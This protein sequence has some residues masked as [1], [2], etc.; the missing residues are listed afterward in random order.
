MTVKSLD[1]LEAGLSSSS[2]E[3]S[4]SKGI[5]PGPPFSLSLPNSKNRRQGSR[6]GL[7]FSRMAFS[8]RSMKARSFMD[9]RGERSSSS[10][11]VPRGKDA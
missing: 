3:D 6:H 8:R 5:G 2:D 4:E 11:G 9:T 1:F 7:R 10:E